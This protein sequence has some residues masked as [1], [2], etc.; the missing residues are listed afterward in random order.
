MQW[1]YSLLLKFVSWSVTPAA[2]AADD[3]VGSSELLE[4]GN[5]GGATALAEDLVQQLNNG[6]GEEALDTAWSL[7]A[8]FRRAAN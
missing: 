3:A 1:L 6:E 4:T 2:V 8:S 7:L 5:A